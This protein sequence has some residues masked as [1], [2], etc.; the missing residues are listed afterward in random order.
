[1]SLFCYY[2]G[3]CNANSVLMPFVIL[4]VYFMVFCVY[5][6]ACMRFLLYWLPISCQCIFSSWLQSMPTL[7]FTIRYFRSLN[8]L[9]FVCKSVTFCNVS[10][11][12][13][14]RTDTE[15]RE[16]YNELGSLRNNA[17]ASSPTLVITQPHHVITQ[18][19]CVIPQ[20]R[21]SSHSLN[22]S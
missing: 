2:K 19:H 3:V 12:T 13:N 17:V 14:R 6:K 15:F 22:T 10:R 8:C 5:R 18:S 9:F 1:M 4:N 16:E 11:N 20:S 7:L 21:T